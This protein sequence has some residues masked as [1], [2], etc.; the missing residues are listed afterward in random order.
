MSRAD[1]DYVVTEYGVAAL[2]GTS[3]IERA[4]ALIK[5]AH[6]NFRDE[7]EEKAK[8]RAVLR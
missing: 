5:I 4:Q 7:L 8:Q 6:P 3:L 2:R 1:V